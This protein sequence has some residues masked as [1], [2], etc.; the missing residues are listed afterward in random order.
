MFT[1]F[2]KEINNFF[3]SLIGYIVIIV[4]LLVN[5]LFIW[6][7]PGQFNIL[8]SG[9]ST[10]Q[11][12]FILSP[13][14][15]LFLVPAVTMRLISDEKKSGTIELLF[16]RQ[17]SDF[18]IIFVKYLA[19]VS[20]VLFSILPSLIYFL[21]IYY[22]G[23]PVGNIDT[24]ATWGSYIGLFF[25]ASVYASIGIFASSLTQN[26]IIAF[27]VSML[28]S[29]FFYIGFESISSLSFLK[30]IQGIIINLGIDEHYKSISRGVIDTRDIIY[31]LSVITGFLF[32][33]KLVLQSRK[34]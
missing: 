17:L 3:S 5:S 8:D 34:W 33:T 22:L 4:F 14:I 6:V 20:L 11:S 12:L 31:F 7:F 27:I 13:W 19:G 21:S 16:T 10:L 9:Y 18:Q 1:L 23:N 24:G 25:L 32:A 15:F 2:K 28:L 26:Q 29:F 30:S